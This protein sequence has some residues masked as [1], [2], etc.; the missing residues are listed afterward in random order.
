MKIDSL[1]Q[2]LCIPENFR[3]FLTIFN[4]SYAKLGV[5][6]EP[7]YRRLIEKYNDTANYLRLFENSQYISLAYDALKEFKMDQQGARLVRYSEFESSLVSQKSRLHDL[8]RYKLEEL[9]S[10]KVP[11]SDLFA[12][13]QVLF[14]QL[15]VM[16]S[17]S[18]LVGVS[19]TLHF[20]LP[21]L[22]MPVDRDSILRFCY[23]SNYVPP[24][25]DAQF[26]R[27]NEVFR[28]Y[29]DLTQHLGLKESDADGNWWNI[30]VPKRIDNAIAGFWIGLKKGLLKFD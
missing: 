13:F 16:A 15:N 7:S 2:L 9:A 19:K 11:F 22:V 5:Y 21:N 29:F 1:L 6:K 10:D 23:G 4:E 14:K 25:L 17:G 30:S 26:E 27:F 28:R 24:S 12:E 3:K 20:M 18:K 8:N